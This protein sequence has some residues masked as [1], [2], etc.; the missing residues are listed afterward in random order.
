MAFPREYLGFSLWYLRS[1]QYV[2]VADN[3]DFVL[4]ALGVDY[5][6]ENIGKSKALGKM[7]FPN[8]EEGEEDKP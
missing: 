8:G 7:L 3:S 6:E 2:T 4:T 5:V 1:K